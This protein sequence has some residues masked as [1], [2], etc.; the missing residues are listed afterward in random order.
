VG[1]AGE[2]AGELFLD[3]LRAEAKRLSFLSHVGQLAGSG[4]TA[5]Q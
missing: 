2:L 1:D 4:L 3:A 5:R